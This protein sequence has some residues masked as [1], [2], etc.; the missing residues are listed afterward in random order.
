MAFHPVLPLHVGICGAGIMISPRETFHD[1]L[2]TGLSCCLLMMISQVSCDDFSSFL[3]TFSD[4][5]FLRS[6]RHARQEMSADPVV[7]EVLVVSQ[8]LLALLLEAARSQFSK[9][10]LSTGRSMQESR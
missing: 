6:Q 4:D 1:G 5:L 7:L 10:L 8:Q 3:K 9:P 2:I